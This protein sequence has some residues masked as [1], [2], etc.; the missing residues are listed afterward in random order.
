MMFRANVLLFKY[1]P[2]HRHD[3]LSLTGCGLHDIIHCGKSAMIIDININYY[4]DS[5][6]WNFLENEALKCGSLT[7]YPKYQTAIARLRSES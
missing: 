5:C 4:H 7:L 2:I 3:Q 1:S 6:P